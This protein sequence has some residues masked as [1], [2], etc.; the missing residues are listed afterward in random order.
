MTYES[1]PGVE[2]LTLHSED[3]QETLCLSNSLSNGVRIEIRNEDIDDV[4]LFHIESRE[5]ALEIAAKLIVFYERSANPP[6]VT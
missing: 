2:R 5:A 3:G 6:S 4:A 1:R